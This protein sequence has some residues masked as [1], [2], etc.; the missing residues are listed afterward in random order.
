[1]EITYLPADETDIAPI[2]AQSRALIERYED[3]VSIDR[4]E[5][6]AWMARKTQKRIGEYRRILCNGE[7]A[8]WVHVCG[9]GERTELDDLYVLP[10]FRNR[11]V[12]TAT[13]RLL[14]R[15]SDKPLFFYIFTRYTDAIRLYERL[16]FHV[17]ETVSPTRAIMTREPG[18]A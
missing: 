2:L 1:M 9:E 12:G 11:G 5:V 8:G 7:T 3:L 18:P 13:L 4:K 17:T 10:P 14:L 15:E 6:F 16:G